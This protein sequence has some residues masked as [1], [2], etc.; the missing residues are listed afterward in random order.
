MYIR[1][2][3]KVTYEERI[4][5][6]EKICSGLFS[7]SFLFFMIILGLIN[8]GLIILFFVYLTVTLFPDFSYFGIF[9]ILYFLLGFLFLFDLLTLGVLRRIPYL[10]TLYY[11]FYRVGRFFMLA[12]MYEDIYYG[13]LSNNKKWKAGIFM[14]LFFFVFFIAHLEVRN[15]GT[16]TTSLALQVSNSDSEL[17]Y[18]GHY[19]DRAT[20]DV[21]G[22]ALIPSDIIR[23]N[24]LRVFV[25][26][27]IS[28]E[29]EKI[30]SD[31]RDEQ[32]AS[33]HMRIASS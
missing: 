18:S 30:L 23:E 11:P 9:S 8:V 22:S 28:H 25:A 29:S 3:R 16:F 21:I 32:G 26:H 12:P 24:V 6:L 1:H 27:T 17:L 33:A 10:R 2:L 19:E 4:K 5:K 31:C 20:E 15:P 13:F 7:L 14:V